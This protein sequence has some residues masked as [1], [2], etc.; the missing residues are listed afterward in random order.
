[1]KLHPKIKMICEEFAQSYEWIA[2]DGSLFIKA[3]PE[4][5][6]IIKEKLETSPLELVSSKERVKSFETS[7]NGNKFVTKTS[8]AITTLWYRIPE[9]Q[10]KSYDFDDEEDDE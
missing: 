2:N 8:P 9:E 10:E 6:L 7:L 1:M 4:F 5:V 3:S